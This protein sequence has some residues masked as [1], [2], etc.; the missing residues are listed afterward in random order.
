M[1]QKR[2]TINSLQVVCDVGQGLNVGQGSHP[3]LMAE[4]SKNGGKTFGSERW[5]S[6]GAIG[7]FDTRVRWTRCGQ[8]RNFTPRFTASD[9]VPYRIVDCLVDFTVNGN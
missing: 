2:V 1:D 8:A 3:V 7:T 4:F 5:S 6:I 9:P